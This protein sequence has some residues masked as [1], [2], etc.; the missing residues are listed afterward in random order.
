MGVPK[1]RVEVADFMEMIAWEGCRWKHGRDATAYGKHR[2]AAKYGA[3]MLTKA[4]VD[5]ALDRGRLLWDFGYHHL[6]WWR[7]RR[8][9]KSSTS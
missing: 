7:R 2:S 6:G 1:E 9:C 5:A 3:E 4:E 8:H